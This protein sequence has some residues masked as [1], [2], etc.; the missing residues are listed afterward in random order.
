MVLDKSNKAFIYSLKRF[1][2]RK[3]CTIKKLEIIQPEYED[4]YNG[5]KAM[6]N[7]ILD[8]TNRQEK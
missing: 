6:L 2:K 3:L 4:Y 7:Y 8:W 1:L 5:N